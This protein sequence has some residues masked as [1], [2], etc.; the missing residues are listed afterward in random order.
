MLAVR[1]KAAQ[2][3]AVGAIA[4]ALGTDQGQLTFA[5]ADV[6]WYLGLAI[7]RL[8][9][10]FD[11]G[12]TYAEEVLAGTASVELLAL[13]IAALTAWGLRPRLAEFRAGR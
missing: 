11:D 2:G 10:Q 7:Q 9:G 4:Q 5:F 13:G 3:D 1:S 12:M 8:Q 6:D